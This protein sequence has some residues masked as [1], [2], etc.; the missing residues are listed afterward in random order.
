MREEGK[1]ERWKEGMME[2]WKDGKRE[3]GVKR[4][5]ENQSVSSA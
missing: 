1:M 2:R 3:G 4:I 5:T